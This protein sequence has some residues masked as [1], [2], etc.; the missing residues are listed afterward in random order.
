MFRSLS[1]KLLALTIGFVMLAEL[2]IFIPSV[3]FYRGTW[4]SD[5][6][7]SGQIAGLAL[8]ANPDA[9]VS[10]E[11]ESELLANAMVRGVMLKRE[12]ARIL[13]LRDETAPDITAR[14]DM[15]EIELFDLIGDALSLL[16]T[17]PDGVIEVTGWAMEG[18]GEYVSVMV[19]EINLYGDMV[20][21][22]RNILIL[23]I[24]ISF[25]TAL[26]LYV[27]LTRIFLEPMENL[28]HKMVEFSEQPED[29]S[30]II[31]P[32]DRRDEIGTAEHQL[33]N[34]QEEIHQALVQKNRLASL[35][36]AV[37]KI[38]HDLRNILT[39]V[40]LVSDRLSLSDDPRVQNLSGALMS[41]INRAIDLCTETLA[42]GKPT[43]IVPRPILFEL[44]PIVSEVGNALSLTP[45]TAIRFVNRVPRDLQLN[46]DPDQIFR[47]LL[48]LARNSVEAFDDHDITSGTITI[49][50]RHDGEFDLID[51]A[52]TGP[53]LPETAKENLFKPFKA[54][55]REGGTGLGLANVRETAEAH[56][57]EVRLMASGPS[58]T[59]FCIALPHQA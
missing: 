48:N 19:D 24:A 44:E 52:D 35:G 51:I 43:N 31:A 54:S 59:T 30:R 53:G 13:M 14:Y 39:T 1:S 40:H 20:I 41:G 22:S 34:M 16:F 25:I 45:F 38:N 29:V 32:S 47:S 37:A 56:G 28:T 18:G 11:L 49:D 7:A 9:A 33:K 2:L 5:H 36:E 58:G 15:R 17:G 10:R 55:T 23:S 42:Y 27:A 6:L 57:G 8:E 12:D 21:Y 3:A 50:A 26:S 4:L 46:A